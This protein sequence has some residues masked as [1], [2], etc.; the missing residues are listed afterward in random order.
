LENGRLIIIQGLGDR[1]K[2]GFGDFNKEVAFELLDAFY[3][4][5][6]NFIDTANA[7]HG[8]QSEEWIGEWLQKTG[9]RDEMVI[10]TKYTMGYKLGQPVQ[11]SNFGGSG[12][13]SMHIAIQD[14]LKRLQTSYV[15][16][17]RRKDPLEFVIGSLLTEVMLVLRT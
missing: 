4:L 14:S 1:W 3:D 10:S 6:G 15:D 17:V 5:G 11:Q 12:T 2:A 16:L 7:Y 13:K 8:G 9:R